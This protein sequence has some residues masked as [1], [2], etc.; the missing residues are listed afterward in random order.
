MQV[1]AERDNKMQM[2]RGKYKQ[3]FSGD[4]C[5]VFICLS[6]ILLREWYLRARRTETNM[7]K[8]IVWIKVIQ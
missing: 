2:L 3:H 8:Y 7:Y 1:H 5:I 4:D 6:K